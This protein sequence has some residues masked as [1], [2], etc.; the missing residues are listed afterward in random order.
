MSFSRASPSIT[1]TRSAAFPFNFMPMR[2]ATKGRIS[3]ASSGWTARMARPNFSNALPSESSSAI[4]VHCFNRSI[5][6]WKLR[7][8]PMEMARPSRTVTF[9]MASPCFN[10]A[11][12]RDFPMPASPTTWTTRP[13]TVDDLHHL[14]TQVG[15]IPGRGPP[16]PRRP[17]GA[18]DCTTDL[19]GINL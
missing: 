19:A 10:S 1:R 15:P 12:R 9:F 6:G 5:R 8:R 3:S 13:F 18:E 16:G 7:F 14:Q 4:P 11:I 2:V 17:G